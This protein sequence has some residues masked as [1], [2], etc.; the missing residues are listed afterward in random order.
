MRDSL[1]HRLCDS[2]CRYRRD[3]GMEGLIM[4]T[5]KALE[6]SLYW[7]QVVLKQSRDPK[8]KQRVS[9][10]IKRLTAQIEALKN[11]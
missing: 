3:A 10:A 6:T 11:S 9:L 1:G 8:Q 7:Q 2:V 4:T 5:L